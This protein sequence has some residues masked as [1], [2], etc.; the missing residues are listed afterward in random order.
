MEDTK[1][2]Q[3]CKILKSKKDFYSNKSRKDLL[4]GFCKK[5]DNEVHLKLN[6]KTPW[7]ILYFSA[8][9]RANNK[10]LEFNLTREYIKSI[11]VSKCPILDLDL[12]TNVERNKNNQYL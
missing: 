1:R 8:K 9:T 10:K 2:C 5:C 6:Q 7:N 12:V 3:H 4:S 11:W